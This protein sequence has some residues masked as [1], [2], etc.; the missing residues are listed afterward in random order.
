MTQAVRVATI[1]S[2]WISQAVQMDAYFFSTDDKWLVNRIQFKNGKPLVYLF[3]W[4]SP[5]LNYDTYGWKDWW[6]FNIISSISTLCTCNIYMVMDI[7]F[8][9]S[10]NNLLTVRSAFD[11]VTYQVTDRPN[12]GCS[13]A[14][15]TQLW[16][17][18][19]PGREKTTG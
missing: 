5:L 15:V 18:L 1:F 12:R 8:V 10:W 7:N 13:Q 11:V 19:I 3:A 16:K 17:C 9:N 2:E 4:E 14:D 6:K